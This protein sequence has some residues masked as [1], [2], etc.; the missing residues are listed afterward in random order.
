LSAVFQQSETTIKA[1]HQQIGVADLS[2][3]DSQSQAEDDSP[4]SASED[5]A[6]SLSLFGAV[7]LGTGV[8]IGAGIFAL[9]GQ[10]AALAGNLFPL[11][12][13][14]AAMVVAFSA[15]S[16]VKLSNEYP[17]SGGIANY[18]AKEYGPG[19]TTG[20]FALFMYISMVINESLVA[21]T[22]GTCV[23]QPIDP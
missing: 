13:L 22:F 17:S 7:S 19:I 6:G 2:H 11:A 21:R 1:T 20:V 23:I 3:D 18:L 15:Y 4:M 14:G 8:M 16:Y 9:T 12:I 10:V 5:E